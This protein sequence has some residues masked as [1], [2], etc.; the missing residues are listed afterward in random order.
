MLGYGVTGYG[1]TRAVRKRHNYFVTSTTGFE[2]RSARSRHE[3]GI[4]GTYVSTHT[5]WFVIRGVSVR[6]E[7]RSDEKRC[8]ITVLI[9]F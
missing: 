8:R 9:I 1:E 3:F 5:C 2:F 7:S 4:S 6:G